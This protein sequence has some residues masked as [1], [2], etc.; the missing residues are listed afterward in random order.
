MQFSKST[1]LL[2]VAFVTFTAAAPGGEPHKGDHGG[3][4]D[5]PPCKPLFQSCQLN[6]ECCGDLCLLGL[7]T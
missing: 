6:S 2:A 3:H 7:C 1:I 4:D 5:Q